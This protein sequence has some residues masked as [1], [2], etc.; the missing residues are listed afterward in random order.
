MGRWRGTNHNVC[1]QAKNSD[2]VHIFSDEEREA[3]HLR[4]KVSQSCLTWSNLFVKN[5]TTYVGWRDHYQLTLI[6]SGCYTIYVLKEEGICWLFTLWVSDG[7]V[8]ESL[9]THWSDVNF[10]QIQHI[11]H[12]LAVSGS[13]WN[14]EGQE[15]EEG[16]R[17]NR[18][19]FGRLS[20]EQTPP[21]SSDFGWSRLVHFSSIFDE[22]ETS[23]ASKPKLHIFIPSVSTFVTGNL[24]RPPFHTRILDVTVLKSILL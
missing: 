21:M 23:L 4:L 5:L 6:Y 17:V 22:E 15:S 16:K 10:I 8:L 13:S 9:S 24:Q 18:R 20:V 2:Q 12:S 11:C 19:V 14:W 7:A 1:A 3:D